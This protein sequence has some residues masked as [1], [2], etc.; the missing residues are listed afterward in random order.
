MSVVVAIDFETADRYSDSAC[1]LG[2][3]RIEDNRITEEWYHL[4]Q[5]P[6]PRVYFTHIHGL[7]RALL[8]DQPVFTELWSDMS[9]FWAGADLFVAHN[10]SFDRRILYGCCEAFGLKAP[11]APFACTVK[12]SRRKLRLP[13]HRLDD[14]CAYLGLELQHHNAAS[15][16]RAAAGI[17]LYLRQCGL[18]DA[19]MLLGNPVSR[20]PG[21]GGVLR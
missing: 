13:R 9:A 11:S 5:P 8:K 15:D 2:M 17:Y 16:A 12:G 7:T 20:V 3:A 10:A 4:I 21:Q 18:S 19:D 14:V 1:A 6:R